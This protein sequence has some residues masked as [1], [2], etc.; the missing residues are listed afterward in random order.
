MRILIWS[1]VASIVLIVQSLVCL[2][3]NLAPEDCPAVIGEHIVTAD[4]ARRLP[5]ELDCPPTPAS[6]KRLHLVASSLP[7]TQTSA[8]NGAQQFC[9]TS[10]LRP[11]ACPIQAKIASWTETERAHEEA[12]K[13]EPLWLRLRIL[14][15]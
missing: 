9:S 7:V 3:I 13:S 14:L 4:Y 2:Q 5:E 12:V 6:Q 11:F 1:L 10:L 8:Q 15:I